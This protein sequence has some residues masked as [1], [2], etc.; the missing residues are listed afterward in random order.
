MVD[1]FP[2]RNLV[3]PSDYWGRVVED[4]ITASAKSWGVTDQSLSGLDRAGESQRADLARQI[5]DL[6]AAFKLV[7]HVGSAAAS[8]SGFLLNPGWNTVISTSIPVPV[9]KTSL[10]VIGMGRVEIKDDGPTGGSTTLF[11]WPFSPSLITSEYGWRDTGFHSGTDFAGG[12]ASAGSPIYAPADGTVAGKGTD[13]SRG[14]YINLSHPT[15]P[16]TTTRYFHMN[17]P[18]PLTVGQSVTRGVTILGYVGNT[19][20]S[21]G[22]HLHWETY[23]DGQ[24]WNE[25][26]YPAMNPRDFMAIFGGAPEAPSEGEYSELRARVV[27]AGNPSLDFV[28]LRNFYTGY[29]NNFMYPQHGLTYSGTTAPVQLDVYSSAAIPVDSFHSASLVAYGVFS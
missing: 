26:S 5:K 24:P 15:G 21:F 8:A 10:N 1:V 25:E 22:A 27:I 17:A 28:P 11:Q 19:G 4:R 29:I 12:A 7:P 2:R 3:G 6:E 13:G 23:I 20:A 9:D 14:N 16:P 18:S